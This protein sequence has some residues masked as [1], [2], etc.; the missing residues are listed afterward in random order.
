VNLY[1]RSAVATAIE[2]AG[3]V[4][5]TQESAYPW[6]GLN[7]IVVNETEGSE[8]TLNLRIPEWSRES[9]IRINQR[10]EEVNGR[11]G[12]YASIT[13]RWNSGD[14]LELELPMEARFIEA[15][16]SVEE[17]L[18]QLA[19]KRGPLVFCL[20]SADLPDGGRISDVSLPPDVR[21]IARFEEDL[22]GGVVALRGSAEARNSGDWTHRLYR[23]LRQTPSRVFN[24]R[25]VPYFAWGNRGPGEMTVWMPRAR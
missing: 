1:G 3:P 24:I 10:P 22:L 6:D 25:L 7:R 17:T 21:L 8:F 19:V 14:V 13:R 12:S 5:L 16:P 9:R 2:G 11:P 4:R 23:Y 18:N 20:E 15:N